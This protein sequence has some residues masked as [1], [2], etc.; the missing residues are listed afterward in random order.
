MNAIGMIRLGVFFLTAG[1]SQLLNGVDDCPNCDHK[2]EK[3]VMMCPYCYVFLSW[4]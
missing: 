4:S 3:G 1:L 2:I